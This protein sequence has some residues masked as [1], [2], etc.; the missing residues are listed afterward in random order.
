MAAPSLLGVVDFAPLRVTLAGEYTN[1][2]SSRIFARINGK[3]T[4]MSKMG[5]NGSLY[6][7]NGEI[8]STQ[9]GNTLLTVTIKQLPSEN[10]KMKVRFLRVAVDNSIVESEES[11]IEINP[12]AEEE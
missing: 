3:D 11:T 10:I 8:L 1:N 4:I 12:D 7:P 2:Y 9:Q 6:L 5:Y